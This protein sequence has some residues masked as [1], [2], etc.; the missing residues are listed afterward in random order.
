MHFNVNHEIDD[1]FCDIQSVYNSIIMCDNN[2]VTAWPRNQI[3][4]CQH[5]TVYS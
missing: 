3:P 4:V 1:I 5:I 2:L